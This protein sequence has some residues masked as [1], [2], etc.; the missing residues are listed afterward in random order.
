MNTRM[1][2]LSWS[3]LGT[4]ALSLAAACG[5]GGDDQ[6]GKSS[7]G[8]SG[9]G[10]NS[11]AGGTGRR[12]GR[13]G[14]ESLVRAAAELTRARPGAAAPG[15]RVAPRCRRQED[16]SKASCSS[17]AVSRSGQHLLGRSQGHARRGSPQPFSRGVAG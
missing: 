4:S 9:S 8:S 16:R 1:S 5:G 2:S 12:G 13:R 3:I 15:A 6:P 17:L 10:A 7:G 11:G 14:R